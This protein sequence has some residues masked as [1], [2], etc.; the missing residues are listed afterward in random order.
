MIVEVQ[1][2]AA[3]MLEVAING[4]KVALSLGALLGGGRSY[5]LKDYVSEAFL[6]HR[7]I[8][9]GQYTADLEWEDGDCLPGDFYYAEIRQVNGQYAWLSPVFVR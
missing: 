9:K 6:I 7:A 3:T 1:G 2:E 4:K 8:Q 5:H